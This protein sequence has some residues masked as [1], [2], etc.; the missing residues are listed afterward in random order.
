MLAKNAFVG[1]TQAQR[2]LARWSIQ[3]IAFPLIAA[4]SQVFKDMPRHQVHRL[5]CAN[6]ALKARRKQNAPDLYH[7]MR[8]LDSHIGR[9]THGVAGIL[10]KDGDKTA[11]LPK[12]LSGEGAC[13]KPRGRKRS[14]E[15]VT[16]QPVVVISTRAREQ[17][18]SVSSRVEWD[19]VDHPPREFNALRPLGGSLY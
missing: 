15:Q 14:L 4:V 9:V 12:A 2:G 1:E 6:R 17:F 8:G 3:R 16:P 11:D 19:N 10:I 18:V 7:T 5:G 13:Q